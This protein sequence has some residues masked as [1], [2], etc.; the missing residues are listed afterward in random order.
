MR[1][2]Q[3]I[4]SLDAGGAERMAVNYAN[5]LAQKS[6]YSALAVTRKEGVLKEMLHQNTA[7]CF[8]SKKS[9]V[10]IAAVLRLRNFIKAH[11]IGL[12]HCHGTSFF[13]G[14]L[15]KCLDPKIKIIWHDHYGNSMFL[16]KRK[17]FPLN[18]ASLFFSGIIVVNRQLQEWC[19]QNLFCKNVIY[20]PNFSENQDQ[21]NGKTRLNGLPGKR[22]V[23]LANLR[24]QKNHFL[25]LE[26]AEKLKASHPDWT[27]HLIGQDFNDQYSFGV[28]SK[29][30]ILGLEKN[31]FLYGTR[32]DVSTILDQSDIGILTS[33][34]EGLPLAVLEY[35]AKSKPVV[36]TNVGE[37]PNIVK[38]GMNGKIVAA[39]NAVQFYKAVT[40]LIH[41]TEAGV[42]MGAALASTVSS[43]FS[44][45]SIITQYT[46][47]L[48]NTV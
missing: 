39:G 47:W 4:D 11:Q 20:L 23:C 36:V 5:R 33:D 43:D 7:Y 40:S 35:G 15:V 48:S 26:V 18:V 2:L 14:L 9:T 10:D 29:I 6:I 16:S 28:K 24:P 31:V 34:S 38:D 22:I 17:Q 41:D 42:R 12:V 46:E 32:S 27:F 30:E 37:L 1:I 44:E 21:L 13:M 8:V 19:T 25:L 3:L 45:D